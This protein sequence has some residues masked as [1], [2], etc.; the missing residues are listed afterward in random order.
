MTAPGALT[1]AELGEEKAAWLADFARFERE[2]AEANGAAAATAWLAPLRSAGIAR[3]AEL[4]FPPLKHEEWRY[5]SVAPLA[6]VAFERRPAACAA[7]A[8]A[9][10][11][12]RATYP[13]WAATE[14]VFVDGRF[15]AELS[16]VRPLP[17]GAFAGS[18]AEA[19]AKRREL[20]EPWL[21][22]IALFDDGHYYPFTALNTAFVTDGAFVHVPDGNDVE[23]PIHLVFLSSGGA[24]RAT[25]AHVRALIVLG[26]GARANVVETYAGPDGATYFTNAVTEIALGASAALDHAKVQREGLAAFHIARIQTTQG[27]GAIFRS[28]SISLGGALVRNDLDALLGAEGA[29]CTLDGLYMASGRQHVDNHTLIDHA[30]PHCPSHEHYKG[31]LAGAATG[32]FNGKILVRQDA[33]KTDAR[34]SNENLLLSADATVNTKPQLEIYAD[35]VRC[36][37]GATVGHLDDN[38][39]FYLRARGIGKAD[40]ERLLTYAFASEIVNEIAAEPVRARLDALLHGWDPAGQGSPSEEATA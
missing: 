27:R 12:A 23:N 11:L 25:V 28:R 26:R 30:V 13:D 8:P 20:V 19:C 36:T 21:G 37:H 7:D 29:E 24:G 40:A 34:Q 17:K 35:D 10:V 39:L 33:Q 18:L 6:K 4:G 15:A 38:A 16:R 31:V 1:R 3:F 32:V 22:H 2:R 14:L 9:D 5:T